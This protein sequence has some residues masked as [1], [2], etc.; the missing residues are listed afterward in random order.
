[1]QR[2]SEWPRDMAED[3]SLLSIPKTRRK[4]RYAIKGSPQSA[5]RRKGEYSIWAVQGKANT[6]AL[7]VPINVLTA[8]MGKGPL[9]SVATKDKGKATITVIKYFAPNRAIPFS[10]YNHLQPLWVW[11]D[12]TS[13]SPRKLN[14]HVDVGGRGKASIK[15]EGSSPERGLGPGPRTRAT[16]A[17][18]RRK[19]SWASTVHLCIIIMNTITN[20][21]PRTKA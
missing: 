12:R 17:V 10:F 19:S 1:M 11:A 16:Q 7:N 6:S 5:P 3:Y 9:N 20:N 15:G 14:L 13:I 21:C 8:L 2:K 18:L 4:E